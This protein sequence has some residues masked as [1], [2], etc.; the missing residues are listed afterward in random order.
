MIA[1]PP[2]AGA[3]QSMTILVPEIVVVGAAGAVGAVAVGSALT[4]QEIG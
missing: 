3:T 1:E 4:V 2:S